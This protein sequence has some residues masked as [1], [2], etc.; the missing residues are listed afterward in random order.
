MRL[1]ARIFRA[2]L[3]IWVCTCS[4][5]MYLKSG[6]YVYWEIAVGPPEHAVRAI[7]ASSP[8]IETIPC[9]RYL[10]ESLLVC[11]SGQYHIVAS[12]GEAP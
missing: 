5:S 9:V 12:H 10:M 6:G 11:P 2:S 1:R 8:V 7:M 4:V 3:P